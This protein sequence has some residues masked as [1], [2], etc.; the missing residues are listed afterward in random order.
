MVE[1]LENEKKL[2]PDEE[3][4]QKTF[5]NLFTLNIQRINYREEIKKPL[6]KFHG[7][8]RSRYSMKFLKE[9]RDWLK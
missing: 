1:Y 9:N 7:Q 8:I 3:E 5:K 2:N 6:Y 4:L